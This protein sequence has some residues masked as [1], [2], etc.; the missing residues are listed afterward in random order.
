MC[1]C[2]F[3]VILGGL[4]AWAQCHKAL[5]VDAPPP[6]TAGSAGGAQAE[7]V[8]RGRSLWFCAQ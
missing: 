8:F 7:W 6:P 1:V 4:N 5:V 2:V 3:E